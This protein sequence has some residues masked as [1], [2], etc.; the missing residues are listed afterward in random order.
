MKELNTLPPSHLAMNVRKVETK[1]GKN[2]LEVTL[3]NR[4]SVISFFNRL[5]L[6]DPNGQIVAPALWSDNYVTLQPGEVKHLTVSFSSQVGNLSLTVDG[7]NAEILKK[8][9]K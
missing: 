4:S 9:V 7:W 6:K 3:T 2:T 5:V 8:T 1:D